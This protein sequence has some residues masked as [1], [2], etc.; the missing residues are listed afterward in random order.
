MAAPAQVT[1]DS[2]GRAACTLDAVVVE[3]SRRASD[4]NAASEANCGR[5]RLEGNDGTCDAP[6]SAAIRR[7]VL[8]SVRKEKPFRAIWTNGMSEGV[9]SQR[10]V[11]GSRVAGSDGQLH[12]TVEWIDL[13]WIDGFD[14]AL[15]TMAKKRAR[16]TSRQCT[17]LDDLEE[18]CSAPPGQRPRFCEQPSR[19]SV[20]DAWLRCEAPPTLVCS[21]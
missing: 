9:G 21:E 13:T 15:G 11:I 20:A 4:E 1:S 2:D 12:F 3:V 10:A 17:E 14:A 5:G 6:C 19:K 8:D 16:I 7:C 18:S